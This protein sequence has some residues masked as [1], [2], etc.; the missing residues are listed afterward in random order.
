[1]LTVHFLDSARNNSARCDF[2]RSRETSVSIIY[3]ASNF[4]TNLVVSSTYCVY[5]SPVAGP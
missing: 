1:M 5:F 4:S 3:S 2:E